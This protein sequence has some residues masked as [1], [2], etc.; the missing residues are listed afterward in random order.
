MQLTNTLRVVLG[1]E[2]SAR[3]WRR[4]N[5][6]NHLFVLVLCVMLVLVLVAFVSILLCTSKPS[7]PNTHT[8]TYTYTQKK[9]QCAFHKKGHKNA[10]TCTTPSLPTHPPS[11]PVRTFRSKRTSVIVF[12]V[13]FF[14]PSWPTTVHSTFSLCPTSSEVGTYA[15]LTHIGGTQHGTAQLSSAQ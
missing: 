6:K 15:L 8:H 12:C 4:R 7:K 10:D 5:R 11:I 13:H 9:N 2:H 3:R 1:S 14:L